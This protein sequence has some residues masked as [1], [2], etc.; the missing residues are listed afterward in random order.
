MHSNRSTGSVRKGEYI[1]RSTNTTRRDTKRSKR[2]RGR[3]DAKKRGTK[4][5]G[6][7]GERDGMERTEK[8]TGWSEEGKRR[9]R[10]RKGVGGE[11][12]EILKR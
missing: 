1:K 9:E 10:E 3:K 8:L 7:K 2:G 12:E 6:V 4:R 5:D 11:I